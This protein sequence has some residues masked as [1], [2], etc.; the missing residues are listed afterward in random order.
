MC[1]EIRANFHLLW[2]NVACD[3][4]QFRKFAKNGDKI[5][6]HNNEMIRQKNFITLELYLIYTLL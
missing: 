1:C 3:V 4:K 5:M 6:L 2:V